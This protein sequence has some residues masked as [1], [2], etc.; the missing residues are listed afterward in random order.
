MRTVP[1][2]PAPSS[3]ATS[4]SENGTFVVRPLPSSSSSVCWAEVTCE[5]LSVHV[6]YFDVLR[7]LLKRRMRRRTQCCTAWTSLRLQSR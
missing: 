6:Q 7:A 2:P 1:Y 3:C 5:T 4:K